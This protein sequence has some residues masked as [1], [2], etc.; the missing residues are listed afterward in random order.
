MLTSSVII[1][2]SLCTFNDLLSNHRAEVRLGSIFTLVGE[3]FSLHTR[4]GDRGL[5]D[6]VKGIENDNLKSRRVRLKLHGRSTKDNIKH[7]ARKNPTN[8][9]VLEK[10]SNIHEVNAGIFN[11]EILLARATCTSN[12]IFLVLNQLLNLL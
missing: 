2:L 6:P 4:Y 9:L 12:V 11:A 7:K 8:G 5:Y 10:I 1:Y 3:E